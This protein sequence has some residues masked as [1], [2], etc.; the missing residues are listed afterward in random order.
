[1]LTADLVRPRLRCS[2]GELTIALLDERKRSWL[3]TA[4]ALIALLRR[5]VGHTR[6]EW[7]RAVDAYAGPRVDYVVVRGLAKVL[8]DAATFTPPPL[9]LP[10][11]VLRERL[12]AHGPVFPTPRLFQPQTH[13][14]V[15]ASV[16]TEL[17]LGVEQVAATL[18]A[19]RPAASILQDAG[20]P[21]TPA[22]LL[23]RYNLDLARG[24][25]YWASVL[26]LEAH[27][28]YK[29]LWKYLKLFKLAS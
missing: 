9:P 5:Q 8:S 2:A 14:A 11:A 3:Q 15:V 18:F 19:D 16:A 6:A 17:G 21:W 20:P 22:G 10:P 1:M 26:H 27:G 24:V 25:L 13:D 29:D 4:S 23:A 12:F 28:S 7:E